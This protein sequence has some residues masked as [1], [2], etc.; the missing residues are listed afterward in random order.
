MALL[1][2]APPLEHP[3]PERGAG[4]RTPLHDL[5][6]L[7]ALFLEHSASV[8][9]MAF[10]MFLDVDWA[11][12]VTQYI[13]LLQFNERFA[14]ASLEDLPELLDWTLRRSPMSRRLRGFA[15]QSQPSW[16]L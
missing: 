6:T 11:E 13:Y 5:E 12:N 16:K 3:P 1:Q 2:S 9:E 8:Y 15:E 4:L 7:D 14:H 10:R